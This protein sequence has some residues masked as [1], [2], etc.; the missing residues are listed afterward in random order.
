MKI[1]CKP[2][3][4]NAYSLTITVK[5]TPSIEHFMDSTMNQLL[6]IIL[7]IVNPSVMCIV[8]LSCKTVD[9]SLMEINVMIV[10]IPT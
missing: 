4:N 2:T 6:E 5:N 1:S 10:R 8:L 3:S 9:T 7:L